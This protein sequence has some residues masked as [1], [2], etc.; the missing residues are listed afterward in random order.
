MRKIEVHYRGERGCLTAMIW[1]AFPALDTGVLLKNSAMQAGGI[2][3]GDRNCRMTGFAPCVHA[4][5][6]PK[7]GMAELAFTREPGMGCKTTEHCSGLVVER[8]RAEKN[9]PFDQGENSDY[10]EY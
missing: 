5:F 6:F 9:S 10:Y 4:G 8:A 7:R 3:L 2:G 1:M